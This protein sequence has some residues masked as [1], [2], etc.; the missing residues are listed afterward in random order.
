MY[1][2]LNNHTNIT[3]AKYLGITI[4]YDF[5]WKPHIENMTSKAY[6]TLKFIK[7]NVQ[8]NNQKV[9][10]TAYNTYVRPQLE[11]C[12]PVWHPWQDK[13][14][15][16]V[17]RVQRTAARYVLNDYGKTSSVTE[18]LNT[19]YWQTLQSR[20]IKSSLILLYKSK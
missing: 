11:Y 7:R 16:N 9:K 15:Y 17:E 2:I 18:M 13:L 5:K 1:F 14:N 19:L 3:Y 8:T 4:S 12:A 6:S 10:E 20:R